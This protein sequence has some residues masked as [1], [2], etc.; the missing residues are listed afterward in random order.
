MKSR[1]SYTNE[2]MEL[3]VIEDFLPRPE[4]LVRRED[5]LKV[6]IGLSKPTVDFFKREARRNGTRYQRM[7]RRVLDLYAARYQREPEVREVER[8]IRGR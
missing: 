8:A 4:D 1:I 3:E 6:T 7:I 5:T 2:P